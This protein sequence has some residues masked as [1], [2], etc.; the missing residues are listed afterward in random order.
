MR[1][2]LL[3]EWP[4]L[5]IYDNDLTPG[6]YVLQRLKINKKYIPDFYRS[7]LQNEFN[8]VWEVQKLHH[9][10]L[11]T[12]EFKKQLS[13][14]G[15][16][17]TKDIFLAKYKIYTSDN[18][19]QDKTL[20]KYEWRVKALTEKLDQEVLAYVISE[21]NS[22]LN[23][24]S[25]YLGAISDRSKELFFQKKTVGQ[26]L[27][28]QLKKSPHARLK[29]QVFYRQDYLD[30]FEKIWN[31][32]AQFHKGLTDSLKV[33][34][35]D[36]VIFYQRKLKS[37][38]HLISVCEFEKHHKVIP[39]SSPLF[40]EFKI[41]QNLNNIEITNLKTKEIS[42]L[43]DEARKY[44]FGELNLKGKLSKKQIIELLGYED[45]DYDLNFK[46]IEGNNTNKNLFEAFRII[47]D[48]EGYELDM[49]EPS[50][51]IKNQTKILLNEATINTSVL[52]FDPEIEGNSFDKQLS[53][54][55]WHCLYSIEEDK[56]LIKV[57]NKNFGFKEEYAKIL[58]NISLQADHGNLMQSHKKIIPFLIA[59]NKYNGHVH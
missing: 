15:L 11:L 16:K 58:S 19:A 51:E 40:Q 57:L 21:I 8:T 39:K 14:K 54:Q 9:P 20:Q 3:M 41:W 36:I 18:K 47:L 7:D 28:E 29:N 45:K 53:Y 6:Q 1:E 48:R 31:V 32:Q 34:I 43:D 33:E 24:S 22:N 46:E 42:I 37:Q 27:Y 17:A 25:G 12:D 35:R 10:E 2:W 5:K 30:E 52:D 55:L 13:G 59:G 4:S 50:L 26:Y 23:N 49:S 44:L 38:K 56:E